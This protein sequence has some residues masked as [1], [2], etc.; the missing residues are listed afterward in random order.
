MGNESEDAAADEGD[1]DAW[2]SEAKHAIDEA[3]ALLATLKNADE[4]FDDDSI[5]KACESGFRPRCA[6]GWI[7]VLILT[8]LGI[9]MGSFLIM[10]EIG[11][12]TPW[13]K[14]TA[15]VMIVALGLSS[16]LLTQSANSKSLRNADL[17]SRFTRCHYTKA[18]YVAHSRT[19]KE[20]Q[21]RD[22]AKNVGGALMNCIRWVPVICIRS[23]A[24]NGGHGGNHDLQTLLSTISTLTKFL[25]SRTKPFQPVVCETA[26]LSMCSAANE[27]VAEAQ[28]PAYPAGI[29]AFVI[30]IFIVT[31]VVLPAKFE[32]DDGM[33]WVPTLSFIFIIFAPLIITFFSQVPFCE[34]KNGLPGGQSVSA[35]EDLVLALKQN[36]AIEGTRVTEGTRDKGSLTCCGW[37]SG[38]CE[39]IGKAIRALFCACSGP[40]RLKDPGAT[41][42]SAPVLYKP[43]RQTYGRGR[44]SPQL[45]VVDNTWEL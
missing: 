36:S 32:S 5:L 15:D 41:V 18:F 6:S 30:V 12:G 17:W 27:L 35:R 42:A 34:G 21:Q 7:T 22:T 38:A 25:L 33:G 26:I 44:V 8:A 37:I 24:T 14:S 39:S 11:Q 16:T 10:N 43:V 1:S 19:P 3:K 31:V 28:H 29:F 2:E 20:S 9:S 13:Q 23:V 45:R 40:G 4:G